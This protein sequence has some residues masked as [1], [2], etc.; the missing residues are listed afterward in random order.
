MVPVHDGY[1]LRKGKL[2]LELCGCGGGGGL[3]A[4]SLSAVLVTNL[5]TWLGIVLSTL[6][7]N[8]LTEELHKALEKK[9]ISIKPSFMISRRAINPNK[10][11]VV[12]MMIIISFIIHVFVAI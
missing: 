10:D 6:A 8:R 7:G 1:A 9:G 4:M 11:V 12:C 5:T 3:R 2:C